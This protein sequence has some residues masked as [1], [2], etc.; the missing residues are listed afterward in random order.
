MLP[1]DLFIEIKG[2]V[3]PKLRVG[4]GFEGH[5]LYFFF[6]YS[7]LSSF[8]LSFKLTNS[9]FEM[10]LFKT[11]LHP[12]FLSLDPVN[13]TLKRWEPPVRE[14][15]YSDIWGSD[16]ESDSEDSNNSDNFILKIEEQKG[17]IPATLFLNQGE[18]NGK[19]SFRYYL[20]GFILL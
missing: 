13:F 3:Y 1:H 5:N 20:K 11:T 19:I 7:V 9:S 18:R 12:V 8:S 10:S 6:P 15:D 16:S 17:K 4:V 14:D 2:G